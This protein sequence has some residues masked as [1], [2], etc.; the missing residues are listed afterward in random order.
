MESGLV[1]VADRCADK[2]V[3]RDERGDYAQQTDDEK[4]GVHVSSGVRPVDQCTVS[5]RFRLGIG[6]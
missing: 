2:C 4:R 1:L 5:P 3:D 6:C